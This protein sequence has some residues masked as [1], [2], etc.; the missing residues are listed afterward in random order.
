VGALN[1][2]YL[3]FGQNSLGPDFDLWEWSDQWLSTSGVNI[4]EPVVEFSADGSI[5]KL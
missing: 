5:I 2:A 3:Q 4:L 1:D